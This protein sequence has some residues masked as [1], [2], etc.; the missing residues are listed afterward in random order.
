MKMLTLFAY[1]ILLVTLSVSPASALT[2]PETLTYEVSWKGMKAGSAVQEV[3]AVGEELRIV[4]TIH[5]S[6]FLS[7]FFISIDNKT[8]SVIP[9]QA[10]GPGLPRFFKENINEGKFHTQKEARFN[11]TSLR[12]DSKDLLKKTETSDPIS[13]R[14]YDSLSSVYYIRS[15]ELVPGQSILFDVYDFK[16]I[17]NTEVRVVKREEIRTPLGKF[18]TLMVTSQLKFEGV[19]ARVGN[20]TLWLTDDIRHIPVRMRIKVKVG[21]LELT[22]VKGPSP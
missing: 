16:H 10:T 14:T 20:A 2:V 8:E 6:G 7:S 15:I 11:F 3:T 19:P 4:Q 12:V 17:W 9:R 1:A 18:K 13:A 22:L 21:E 5:S